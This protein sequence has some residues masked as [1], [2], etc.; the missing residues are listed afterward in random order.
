MQVTK[1]SPLLFGTGHSVIS[2]WPIMN[3]PEGHVG[4]QLIEA[5]DDWYS[6]KVSM[7][8]GEERTFILSM[9]PDPDGH[10]TLKGKMWLELEVIEERSDLRVREVIPYRKESTG[11]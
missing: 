3:L 5:E 1:Q 6:A 8:D 4:V 2:Q 11:E 9:E 7:P 10:V